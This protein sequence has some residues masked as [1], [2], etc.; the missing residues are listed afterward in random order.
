MDVGLNLIR[1]CLAVHG[2]LQAKA[3][4][5]E[6]ERTSRG[7]KITVSVAEGALYRIGKIE[8]EG[9][10]L[11]T[12]E[13]I[14]EGLGL[15]RGDV[16]NGEI[17]Y[18]AFFVRLAGDYRDQGYLQYSADPE[19]TFQQEPGVPEGIVDY[20]VTVDEG[21]CFILREVQFAGNAT[22]R[23]SV[24]R[25]ALRLR[26]GKPFSQR[27]FEESVKNLNDL[28]LFELIDKEKDV[29]YVA[30]EERSQVTLKIKVKEKNPR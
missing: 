15:K 10:K 1:N 14:K 29:D 23:D 24:L 13:R 18:D 20:L 12:P 25:A 7:H 22:T 27:L 8:I 19:P 3:G 17:I 6:V 30:D 21:K 26:E 28:N 9:A 11:F 5:A 16:A 4:T 2:Y